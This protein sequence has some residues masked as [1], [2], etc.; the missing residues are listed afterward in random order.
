MNSLLE[1][2][3]LVFAIAILI[4]FG[5]LF[6]VGLRVLAL[7]SELMEHFL[8]IASRLAGIERA[9]ERIHNDFERTQLSKEK[10]K[11]PN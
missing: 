4:F 2:L 5:L 3:L 1:P 9:L 11:W 10:E 6:W 8:S 7:G